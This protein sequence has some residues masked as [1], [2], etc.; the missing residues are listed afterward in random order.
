MAENVA[1]FNDGNFQTEVLDSEEPVLVDFWAPW[2][3]PCRA[4]APTVEEVAGEYSGKVKVGKLNS[5]TFS[6]I[7]L[8]SFP[9]FRGMAERVF[10]GEGSFPD[11]DL[12]CDHGVRQGV[13]VAT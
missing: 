10:F 8:L 11:L 2:C 5:A 4:L 12:S 9:L 7:G 1:E 6:A 13:E 3:G